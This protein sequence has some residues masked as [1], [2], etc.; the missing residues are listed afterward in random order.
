MS[1]GITRQPWAWFA[2]WVAVAALIW[3][4]YAAGLGYNLVFHRDNN[5]VEF[6]HDHVAWGNK[7]A[8][9]WQVG[10]WY[11]FALRQQ[12]GVLYGKVWADGQAEPAGWMFEQ[13]GWAARS[14]AAGLNGGSHAG[15][16]AAFDD[17]T[18][19]VT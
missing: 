7:Y 17:V 8:F 4:T 13:R 2:G 12:D 19:T 9:A 15:A 10:T 3:A 16:S 18:I 11:H 5:T 6:L 14:G 1:S